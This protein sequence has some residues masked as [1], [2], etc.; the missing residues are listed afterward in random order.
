VP[1]VDLLGPVPADEQ[2]LI[3]Y[4]DRL[5]RVEQ[6]I[7]IAERRYADALARRGELVARLDELTERA[8]SKGVVDHADLAAAI[9]AARNVLDRTPTPVA[10]A[11]HLVAA[12]GAWLELAAP[13]PTRS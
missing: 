8:R 13:V 6:A 9:A 5:G 12:A 4:T 11:E 10:V 3:A 2:A 7:D 1:D